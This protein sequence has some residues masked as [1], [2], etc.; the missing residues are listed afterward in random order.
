ME[1]ASGLLAWTDTGRAALSSA[2]AAEENATLR[3]AFDLL[4]PVAF[5]G[6]DA[7]QRDT[8]S[9]VRRMTRMV[10]EVGFGMDECWLVLARVV[11]SSFGPVFGPVATRECYPVPSGAAEFVS[12]WLAVWTRGHGENGETTT[13]N[14]QLR[15][16][17]A[18]IVPVAGG[19]PGGATASIVT[20]ALPRCAPA[21]GS[22]RVRRGH[23]RRYR[24]RCRR[25]GADLSSSGQ[26]LAEA[27]NDIETPRVE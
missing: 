25:I 7:E 16:V 3:P 24:L 20:P 5:A 11:P 27:V 1:D 12:F 14:P 18:G 22:T 23:G 21:G 6:R 15:P 8:G 17:T 26:V 4:R 10:P 19:G 9:S 13:R 2:S